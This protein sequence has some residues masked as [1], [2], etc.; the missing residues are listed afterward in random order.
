MEGQSMVKKLIIIACI[1]IVVIAIVKYFK[2]HFS[3]LESSTNE[4]KISWVEKQKMK[5]VD[6]PNFVFVLIG[7][8]GFSIMF[9]VFR[10]IVGIVYSLIPIYGFWVPLCLFLSAFFMD[11]FLVKTRKI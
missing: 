9:I 7:L 11:K 6:W 10:L 5:M 4:D 3:N 8:G 1:I 2:K